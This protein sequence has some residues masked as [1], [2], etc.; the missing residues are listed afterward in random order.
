MIG[1]SSVGRGCTRPEEGVELIRQAALARARPLMKEFI[2]RVSYASGA[3][4][5]PGEFHQ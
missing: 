5:S 4:V 2:L 1:T 3:I